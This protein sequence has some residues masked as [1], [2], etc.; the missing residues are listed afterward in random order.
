MNPAPI[1]L[2]HRGPAAGPCAP[3]V[4]ARP[5]PGSR[6]RRPQGDHH[7][8]WAIRDAATRAD[9][10]RL[11]ADSRAL[12]ADGHHR[13]AAYLR[14]QE[15]SPGTPRGPRSGHAGRPGRHAPVPRRDP[16]HP[17]RHH[18]RGTAEGGGELRG[19]HRPAARPRRW[20]R[21]LRARW[22]SPTGES[23]RPSPSTFR[24]ERPRWRSS[25]PRCSRLWKPSP[26]AWN[27]TT[28][29]TTPSR[30]LPS[31][32]GVAVLMPAI[33]FDTVRRIVGGDRLLPEKA[34]LLPAQAQHG[35]PHALA[36][37]RMSRPAETSTSNRDAAP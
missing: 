19:L 3:P 6:V 9:L 22:L 27:T 30:R 7:R 18:P 5:T 20:P 11:L 21:S 10:G 34:T 33:D 35:R 12:L 25:M 4:A 29:S 17:G 8:V 13:Y 32:G 1:L 36:A 26:T 31:T 2:V 15:A 24:R 14:M 23:G 16:P 37:R 28:R